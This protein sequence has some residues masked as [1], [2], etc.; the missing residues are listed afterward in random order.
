MKEIREY[1]QQKF[2]QDRV[3]QE[4]GL[5]RWLAVRFSPR[6]SCR[7]VFCEVLNSQPP[8]WCVNH[9][10][11][12]ESRYGLPPS[13]FQSKCRTSSRIARAVYRCP[14]PAASSMYLTV[15][16]KIFRPRILTRATQPLQGLYPKGARD[17]SLTAAW[18]PLVASR[19]VLPIPDSSERE[20]C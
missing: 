6:E 3:C 11:A 10:S 18:P 17:H 14:A 8:V 13:T 20:N 2:L 7:A 5:T 4:T 9:N 1:P 12:S 19:S 16:K 15:G